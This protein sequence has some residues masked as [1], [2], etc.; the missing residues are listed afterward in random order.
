M[1]T[2]SE[3]EPQAGRLIPEPFDATAMMTEP[4]RALWECMKDPDLGWVVLAIDRRRQYPMFTIA[5]SEKHQ[6][7]TYAKAMCDALARIYNRTDQR[8]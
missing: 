1:V 8:A 3:Q 7:E 6:N 4:G 5:L 2:D